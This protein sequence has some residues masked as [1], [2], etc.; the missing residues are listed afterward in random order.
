MEG[1]KICSCEG[2]VC[3]KNGGGEH[4]TMRGEYA[5]MKTQVKGIYNTKRQSMI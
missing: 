4:D 5:S 1:E 2:C 3:D